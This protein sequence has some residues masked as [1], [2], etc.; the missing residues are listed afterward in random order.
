MLA[1]GALLGGLVLLTTSCV[2]PV[3][4]RT[5][6]YVKKQFLDEENLDRVI[7]PKKMLASLSRSFLN[8][9][10]IYD[11]IYVEAILQTP[12]TKHQSIT[13]TAL[14][15][16]WPKGKTDKKI[17]KMKKRLK[18][19]ICFDL[20]AK[21]NDDSSVAAEKWEF[22]LEQG[23]EKSKIKTLKKLREKSA[24]SV[25]QQKRRIF[26]HVPNDMQ[27][28]LES[29]VCFKKKAPFKDDLVLHIKPNFN[30]KVSDIKLTWW[31]KN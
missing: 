24:K 3:K 9:A 15:K 1:R 18:K 25:F 4:I 21:S 31:F 2:T 19:Y 11:T 29:R 6:G 7:V 28:F 20:L 5:Q 16:K 26:E 27:Y 14:A 17:I 30:K 10:N 23:S 22:S 13:K 12:V 8:E